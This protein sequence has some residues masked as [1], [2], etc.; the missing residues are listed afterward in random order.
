MKNLISILGL[1]LLFSGSLQSQD[2]LWLS[3]YMCCSS[4]L[5][6]M[7]MDV[8][9]DTPT[10][11]LVNRPM[12]MDC[13]NAVISAPDGSLLFYTNGDYIANRYDD[14]LLNGSGISPGPYA[15]LYPNGQPLQQLACIL[16]FDYGHSQLYHL[17][18]GAYDG[19][20]PS[21][22][23]KFLYH[24]VIDMSLDSGRG[25][26]VIKSD[27][28]LADILTVGQLSACRHANGR[29]WWLVMPKYN[30]NWYHILLVTP[31][32]VIDYPQQIGP[33]TA[34]RSGAD[35]PPSH[36]TAAGMYDMTGKMDSR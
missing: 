15:A 25:A 35:R 18:H 16:P 4:A 7:T 6:G 30:S 26:V 33:I 17:F 10:I 9:N 22:Q 12:W 2:N 3:G 32:V 11:S 31:Y 13:T 21:G 24:S 1:I 5:G 8:S 23:P 20:A 19:T 34:L 27:S 36:L 28:I 29:D 14:T